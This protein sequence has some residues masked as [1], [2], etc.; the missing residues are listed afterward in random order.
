[1]RS[2]TLTPMFAKS[3]LV[4]LGG[5]GGVDDFFLVG[6]RPRLGGCNYN[7]FRLEL[8]NVMH[9]GDGMMRRTV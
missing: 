4:V 6:W 8:I 3:S 7:W 5:R 9:M 2:R 1:M